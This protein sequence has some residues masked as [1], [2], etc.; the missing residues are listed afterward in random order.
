MHNE[1][2]F[3]FPNKIMPCARTTDTTFSKGG[4]LP[5]YFRVLPVA[6]VQETAE[7]IQ[8]SSRINP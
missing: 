8:P 2:S 4:V 5:G 1:I 6:R 3:G 7:P